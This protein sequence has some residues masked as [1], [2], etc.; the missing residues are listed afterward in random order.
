MSASV[1]PAC[2]LC[3]GDGGEVLW[4]HPVFR[5]VLVDEAD[6]P[7]FCRVIC[8][9][10]VKEMT[11]LAPAQRTLMANAVWAVEA[12]LREVMQPEKVNLATL[13]NMTPHVHW[14]V[15][16]RFTDDRHF[17]SPVWAEPRRPADAASIAARRARL[18]QLR[19]AVRRQLDAAGLTA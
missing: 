4:Q 7:G 9:E 10:H 8:H 17:P 2:E 16:P 19:E 1:V 15:I 14:H 18:P 13:G 12:A 11:D 6:Y 3:A 5:V